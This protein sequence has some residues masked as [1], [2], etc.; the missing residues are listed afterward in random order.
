MTRLKRV[1][2]ANCHLR[3]RAEIHA[4]MA[5]IATPSATARLRRRQAH[6]IGVGQ[7]ASELSLNMTVMQS[8]TATIQIRRAIGFIKSMVVQ[9]KS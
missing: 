9:R 6:L 2:S 1:K 5:P 8:Q 7:D 4:S 3:G